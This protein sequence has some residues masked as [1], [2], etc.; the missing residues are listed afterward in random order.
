MTKTFQ[1]PTSNEHVTLDDAHMEEKDTQEPKIW[2]GRS[3]LKVYFMNPEI[4][5]EW[6]NGTRIDNIMTWASSWNSPL[7]DQIPRFEETK[8]DL[9]AD[10]RVRFSG[11]RA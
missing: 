7:Y 3:V 2:T 4:L 10:I 5:E 1:N 9:T 11:V 8:D 6:A